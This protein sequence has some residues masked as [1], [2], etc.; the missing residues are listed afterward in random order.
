[1]SEFEIIRQ[2]LQLKLPGANNPLMDEGTLPQAAVALI[3]RQH[4]ED[5]ELL[6]IKRAES[7]HDHWSG[8]LALPG[9]RRQ[10]EDASLLATAVRETREEVGLDLSSG[11]ETLGCLE[12]LR[13]KSHFAPQIAVTPVVAVAPPAYHLRTAE[14]APQS[15]RLNQEVAAAI[16]VP[17]SFLKRDGRSEMFRFMIAGQERE[18]PSYPTAEGLIW[19]MTERIIT[20]FLSLIE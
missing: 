1:M 4:L 17:I 7:E 15:L 19:G 9:G 11:G 10:I 8:H 6:I 3:L 5:A 16:W 12:T 2:Q 13:P 18:W 20:D 14:D